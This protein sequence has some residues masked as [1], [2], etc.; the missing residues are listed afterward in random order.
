MNTNIRSLSYAPFLLA[1]SLASAHCGGDDLECGPGATSY[2]DRCVAKISACA[3]GTQLVDGECQPRCEAN[4][5]WNGSSCVS[6]FTCAPGTE[7]VDGEC[8]LVCT[9]GSYWDGEGCATV[10]SCADGT[11]FDETVGSCVANDSL[12]AEGTHFE[13]GVCVPD[14]ESCGPGTH[15]DGSACVPDTLPAPDVS[16]STTPDGTAQFDTPASGE[17]VTLGGTVDTPVDGD[18]DGYADPD[19]DRF[20]FTASA[21]TWLRIHATSEGAAHPAFAI[22]SNDVGTNGAPLWARYAINPAAIET[23]REIYIPRDGDYTIVVSDYS[24]VTAD[25]FGWMALPVGGDDFTYYMTIDNLG[26]PTPTP[27]SSVPASDKGSVA[28]GS[29]AF[30]ELTGLQQHDVRVLRNLGN[31]SGKTNSDV[32]GALMLFGPDGALLRQNVAYATGDDA[33]I[34]FAATTAGDHLVVVDH[35]LTIGPNADYEL[36][37]EDVATV[38]CDSADCSTGSIAEDVS[39]LLSWDIVEGAVFVAGAYVPDTATATLQVQMMDEGLVPIGEMSSASKYG[40]AKLRNFV[41]ADQRIYLL[42]RGYSGDEIPSYTLDVRTPVADVL[43]SGVTQI[44]NVYDMPVDTFP[45]SGLGRFSAAAGQVVVSNGFVTSS[46]AWTDPVESYLSTDFEAIPPTLDVTDAAFPNSPLEPLMAFMPTAGY[47]LYQ[48]TDGAG[49]D[50]SGATYDSAFH[51]LTP[52]DLGTP[53]PS[54]PSTRTGQ[55]VDTGVGM[56][57]FAFVGAA[58]QTATVTV[59]PQAAVQFQPEVWIATPGHRE[60]A[61]GTHSWVSEELGTALGVLAR[62]AAS[63]PGTSVGVPHTVAY[64]GLQLVFVRD[65]GAGDP[66]DTFDI[67]VA[68]SN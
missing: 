40:P 48:A 10:P 25:V 65:A 36:S 33:T 13:G 19:Y 35:L 68:V 57:V 62:D 2:G 16:E 38:D 12:C 63:S 49:A 55:V 34:L 18:G 53:T 9:S 45:T 24:H 39:R 5:S 37:A 44:L 47:R 52:T 32:F 27:L 56:A 7:L 60:Y 29:L 54:T 50:I 51:A 46:S 15:L 66:T 20:T 67:E 26:D 6:D 3:A 28:E 64:D 21:G 61:S 14:T 4:A 11:T 58:G 30:V 59:T 41:D 1:L 17:S 23:Q 42:L 8:V 43:T 22:I 31:P